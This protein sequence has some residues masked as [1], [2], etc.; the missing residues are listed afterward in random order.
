MNQ[1]LVAVSELLFAT[2]IWGFGFTATIWAMESTSS[3]LLSVTRFFG[4]CLLTLPVF[5]FSK[6][7]RAEFSLANLKLSALPGFFLGMTLILQTWGL[8]FTT[9]TKS[10]FITTLYVIL[11]P[12]IEVLIIKKKVSRWHTAWVGLAM[13]GTALIVQ[14][15]FN[16]VNKGD[17]LTLICSAFAAAH[18]ALLGAIGP[19]IKSPFV[20]NFYQSFWA[21]SLALIMLPFFD[22][23]HWKGI[24]NLA[25][26]G[27]ISLTVGSTMLA[28]ALQVKAQK[29]LSASLASLIFLL[30]SPFAMM[31]GI[32]LLGETLTMYQAAGAGLIILAAVGAIRFERA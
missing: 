7:M 25:L 2:L 28:F 3:I 9:A 26:I 24:N 5:Y 4:A 13:V 19:K 27:F 12:V 18:I 23:P 17:V 22:G 29:K 6:E 31:F 11:V 8:E 21:G 30:E 1:R 10:G 14:L 15:Q 16:E 20:F 32:I